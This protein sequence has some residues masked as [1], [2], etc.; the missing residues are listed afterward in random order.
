MKGKAYANRKPATSRPKGDLYHTP[1]SLIWVAE[2]I[3]HKEFKK[4]PILEPCCGKFAISEELEKL[5]YLVWVNDLYIL[6]G[7]YALDYLNQ[8]ALDNNKYIITNPPFPLW[9]K[10]VIKAKTHCRKFMFIGKTDF[11]SAHKRNTSGL[12]KNL[13]AVYIF[14]RKIDL[15]TPLR[16]DGLFH[17]G[18]ANHAW[19]LWDM[20]YKGKPT[21]EI[22]DV[23]QYAKL[24]QFRT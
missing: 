4:H 22:L 14:D 20:H 13:K 3:I 23:Q 24:G 7:N 21:I 19:F 10:F 2:N 5:G 6:S 18:M 15:Q 11:F 8:T 12:W 1:K 17:V 16:N 9:D